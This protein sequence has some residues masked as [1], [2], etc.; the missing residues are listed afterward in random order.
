MRQRWPYLPPSRERLAAWLMRY[1]ERVRRDGQS[2][3]ERIATMNRTNP[4][5]RV[6]QLSGTAGYRCADERR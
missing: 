1:A 2:D 3:A 5:I 6:A 4:E